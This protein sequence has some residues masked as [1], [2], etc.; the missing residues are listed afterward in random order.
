LAGELAVRSDFHI[1]PAKMSFA[2]WQLV[3]DYLAK[4]DIVPDSLAGR[5]ANIFLVIQ[6]GLELGVP[7][8]RALQTI[9][10][11]GR[12]QTG[13]MGTLLVRNIRLAGHRIKWE[14]TEDGC[15]C[16]IWRKGEGDVDPY[17]ATFTRQDAQ[18]AKLTGKENYVRYFKRMA[19]WRSTSE[20]ASFACP[21]VI[22]GFSVIEAMDGPEPVQL[23]PQQAPAPGEA[24][25]PVPVITGDSPA[26]ELTVI[27]QEFWAAQ[28]T[29]VTGPQ[30]AAWEG[31]DGGVS[32]PDDIP[33]ATAATRARLNVQFFRL[34]YQP[35]K[36]V[37]D[38]RR[39]LSGWARAPV[40]N[41]SGLTETQAASLAD[42]LESIDAE[43][44][45]M[46]VLTDKIAGW[47]E[48]WEQEDPVSYDAYRDQA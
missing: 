39:A 23:Q 27:E 26:Q 20:C 25:A 22:L 11:P 21:E 5:P 4:S 35:R 3:C 7:W 37:H 36:H 9:Y 10:S 44:N 41:S 6:M 31:D 8:V 18:D 42:T 15:T 38:V 40:M 48:T 33:L 24:A 30:V 43:P 13:I 45:G 34:G 1:D 2:D 16:L 46:V 47:H 28:E 29:D 19:R 14:E 12:G 17:T 32:G